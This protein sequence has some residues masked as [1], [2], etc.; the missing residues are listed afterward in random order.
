MKN[1]LLI[2]EIAITLG[3]SI[4]NAYLYYKSKENEIEGNEDEDGADSE[5]DV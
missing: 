2:L 3:I 4:Y 5:G 1:K